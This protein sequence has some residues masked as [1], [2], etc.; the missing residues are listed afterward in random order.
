V[1]SDD[2]TVITAINDLGCRVDDGAGAP[3]GRPNSEQACSVIEFAPSVY[4]FVEDRS[5]L[6]YCLPIAFAWSFPVGDT[7]IA[8][9]VRD[10]DGRTSAVKEI[11]LHVG[12]S[13]ED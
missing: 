12:A 3:L 10:L 7:T 8:A 13:V 11:V 2:P 5:Q 9:R 6:Q 1:F 4:G